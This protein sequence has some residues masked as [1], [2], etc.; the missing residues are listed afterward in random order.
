L[1]DPISILTCQDDLT[2]AVLTYLRNT[3]AA[4]STVT[5]TVH[6][7]YTI[8]RD[9]GGITSI[10][11]DGVEWQATSFWATIHTDRT[12]ILGIAVR[13]NRGAWDVTLCDG[14]EGRPTVTCT[15]IDDAHYASVLEFDPTGVIHVWYNLHDVALSY[16]KSNASVTA[17][18][19][20]VLGST[21][22]MTGANED[23]WTYPRPWRDRNDDYLYVSGRQKDSGATYGADD[24]DLYLFRY[25]HTGTPAW[26]AAPGTSTGGLVAVGAGESLYN[27]NPDVTADNLMAYGFAWRSG[28]GVAGGDK[29]YK[30]TV[31]F[32][33][34]DA[35]TFLDASGAAQTMPVVEANAPI[36]DNFTD[37]NG[38]SRPMVCCDADGRFHALY[39]KSGNLLHRLWTSGVGWS[40][41]NVVLA[42]VPY[43]EFHS[44][45][46]V[47][48]DNVAYVIRRAEG[49]DTITYIE[50]DPNDYSS[51]SSPANLYGSTV[52]QEWHPCYDQRAWHRTR[53]LMVPVPFS[54]TA[55]FIHANSPIAYSLAESS[56]WR[57][58]GLFGGR[59]TDNN[60]VTSNT[61]A[62]GTAAAFASASSETLS[63]TDNAIY[64]FTGALT[65]S[66]KVYL[67]DKSSNRGLIG[68]WN[69]TGNQRSYAVAYDQASDRFIFTVSPDGTSASAVVVSADNFGSPSTGTWY[70]I[71]CTHD[72]VNDVITIRVNNGTANSQAHAG[73]IY[74][75]SADFTIGRARSAS[76]YHNGRID[77]VLLYGSVATTGEASAIYNG[78]SGRRFSLLGMIAP[79][80]WSH[81]STATVNCTAGDTPSVT[82]AFWGDIDSLVP[83]LTGADAAS[84]DVVD[85]EDGTVTVT[86]DSAISAGDEEVTLTLTNDAGSDAVD[87]TFSAAGATSGLLLANAAY[88][89]GRL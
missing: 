80:I 38:G 4:V 6:I 85:N 88:F 22:A 28:D 76:D 32:Y 72:P 20:V 5:T 61:G 69:G 79:T 87:L 57:Y 54:A 71:L 77:E 1:A 19:P 40:S 46:L 36:I 47:D 64:D 45:I 70:D 3:E 23:A 2:S 7:N 11:L 34:C 56:S 49:G 25:D 42:S 52:S 62:V 60:T 24:G 43:D 18:G 9:G 30:P 83:S 84:Y 13:K 41:A 8:H 75:S 10:V 58:P 35:G 67:T 81:G 68:K 15:D 17:G 44:A 21:I 14:D 29:Y 86:R 63:R 26:S 27:G 33:D 31:L 82:V 51:W 78:G 65:I 12:A 59:L 74:N 39:T 48:D 53:T 37:G 66:L 73:N 50:S 16:R 89:G 55:P